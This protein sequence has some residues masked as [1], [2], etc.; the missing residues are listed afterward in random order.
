MEALAQVVT[1]L[2]MLALSISLHE[3]GHYLTARL[4]GYESEI[5]FVLRNTGSGIWT[6]STRLY[7]IKN[8]IDLER[9]MK[10]SLGITMSGAIGVLSPAVFMVFDPEAWYIFAGCAA[11]LM[12]YAFYEVGVT[13]R[14]WKYERVSEYAS[15]W[16]RIEPLADDD[17]IRVQ[18]L[19]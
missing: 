2:F 19:A 12:V 9:A 6:V 8:S 11:I 16:W 17:L 1:C 7:K 3:G 14:S 5:R 18:L 10:E 15:L 4:L 13:V